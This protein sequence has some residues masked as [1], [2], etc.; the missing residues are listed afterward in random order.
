MRISLLIQGAP[1]STAA[2]QRALRFA[3]AACAAGHA[4]GRVFFYKDAV[5]IASRFGDDG[6]ARDDWTAFAAQRG[7]ELAVCVSAAARR[8]I[9]DGESLAAGFAIAGL[10]QFIEALEDGDRLVAF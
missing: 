3:R 9:V 6:G 4:L 1:C 2:P 7:I 10:G 8:G 5:A